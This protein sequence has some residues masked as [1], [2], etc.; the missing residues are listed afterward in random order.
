LEEAR[1]NLERSEL[2]FRGDVVG[3]VDDLAG[4]YYELLETAY[5]GVIAAERVA[6]L[7]AASEAAESVVDATPSRELEL[8]QL[9]GELANAR[10]SMQ[11]ASSSFRLQA[12]NIKQRLRLDPADSIVID[13]TLVVEPVA[14]DA[15]RAIELASTLAPRLRRLAISRRQSEIGLERTRGNQSFRVN[16]RFTYGREVQ[17]PRFENL[18]TEPRNSY[19]V[20]V[21]A[22]IPIWDWGERKHRIQ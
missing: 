19:T 20:N 4:D 15:E 21:N 14:V 2:D 17:D 6:D 16:L 5:E 8:D 10:E 22:T 3:M 13:P 11:R 18:W 1:L 9:Q 7:E 12:E